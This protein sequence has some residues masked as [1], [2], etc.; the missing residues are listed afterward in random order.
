MVTLSQ[1][2]NDLELGARPVSAR[3]VF[4]RL[5]VRTMRAAVVSKDIEQ[6][7]NNNFGILRVGSPKGM[8][9]IN[10]NGS[11][12]QEYTFGTILHPLDAPI[13]I[14]VRWLVTIE[15]AGVRI[16]G[17]DDPDG[18]DKPYLVT[19]VYA[20]DKGEQ[21]KA[22]ITTRIGPEDIG[23]KASGDIFA[24]G[25]QLVDKAFFVPGDGEIRIHVTIMDAESGDPEKIKNA[26]STA[27]QA[28]MAGALA[29]VPGIGPPLAVLAKTTGLMD[30]IG[31]DLGATVSHIFG[32]DLIGSIDFV[33]D[34]TF[35]SKFAEHQSGSL[36]RRSDSIPGIVYNFPPLSES[37]PEAATWL[38][39]GHGQG[40]YRAFFRVSAAPVTFQ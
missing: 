36:S 8:L 14:P 40:T 15:I 27:A 11:H 38:F 18:E 28:A 22:V 13:T 6:F 35:L 9:V 4:Q 32:D 26:W 7:Y 5:R 12:Q 29:A 39:R 10:P 34:N 20:I 21:D 16:F 3:A 31:D 19:S 24:Q 33:I 37:G 2:A 17:T 30:S 1:I 25:R 23:P